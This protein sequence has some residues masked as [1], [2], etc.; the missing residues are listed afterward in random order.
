MLP[1]IE[2]LWVVIFPDENLEDGIRQILN[3]PAGAINSQELS[4]ISSMKLAGRDIAD[5]TGLEYCTGVKMLDL[6]LNRIVDISALAAMPEVRQVYLQHNQIVDLSPL[7]DNPG[8]GVG[9]ALDIRFNPLDSQTLDDHIPDLL[10]R[11]VRMQW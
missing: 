1:D 3:K 2:V 6:S 4:R 11:E 9:D 10:E 7:V 8:V 5:L